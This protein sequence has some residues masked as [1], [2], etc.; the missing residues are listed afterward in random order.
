M[1]FR[2]Y[3]RFGWKR[4][5]CHLLVAAAAQEEEAVSFATEHPV[6][7]THP[8]CPATHPNSKWHA[9]RAAEEGWFEPK[10]GSGPR[11][12]RHAPSWVR[13]WRARKAARG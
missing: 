1:P 4:P 9:I 8:E 6:R 2:Y 11:C 10:D 13:G 7:C 12:P 3:R 5:G